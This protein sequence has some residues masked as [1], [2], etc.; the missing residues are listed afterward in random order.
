MALSK[1]EL[2]EL[3]GLH[4]AISHFHVYGVKDLSRESVLLSKASAS[5]LGKVCKCCYITK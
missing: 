1:A 3:I 4:D 2:K 5:Q